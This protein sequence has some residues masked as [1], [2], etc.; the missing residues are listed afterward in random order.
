MNDPARPYVFVEDTSSDYEAAIR[1][2]RQLGVEAPM[3]CCSG[4]ESA[5]RYLLAACNPEPG[6]IILDLRLPDGDGREI[7][8]M[9]RNDP[10]LRPVPVAIW[11]A[12]E[13]PA[14]VEDCYQ[15]GANSF[16]AKAAR[17]DVLGESI[18]QFASLWRKES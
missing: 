2:L 8:R 12:A 18:R 10:R 16:I 5:E 9:V 3:V 6:L 15:H 14:V 1:G 17:R 4:V 11:S 7:L 13:D